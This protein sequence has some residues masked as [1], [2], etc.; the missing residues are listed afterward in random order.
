MTG[1]P[2]IDGNRVIAVAGGAGA[3]K[4]MAFDK[5]SGKEIWRALNSE[6]EEPGYAQPILFVA[7]GK[8]QLIIWHPTAVNSLDP[9]TGK[10]YWSQPFKVSNGISIAMPRLAGD[11]LFVTAFYNGPLMLK[12]DADKPAASVLWR[13]KSSSEQS[14]LTD[15]LHCLMST[16]VIKDG[17]IYGV[18]SY[19]QLRC[20]EA[21]SGKR[22]WE[23]FQATSGQEVRWGNAFLIPHQDRTF[24]FDE[25]GNLILARLTPKGYDEIS[26]AKILEPTNKAMGRDVVWSHPA[27]ANR[28]MYA[29]NDKEFVCVSLAAP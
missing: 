11:L 3:A 24:I 19:G 4:V 20:I 7:A 21:A 28:S 15:G 10:R 14:R 25:R 13:G 26:R 17:H 2:V 16:P 23:T 12:L 29:R 18:C 5:L 6:K 9:E 27:F 1:A 8:R 22:V